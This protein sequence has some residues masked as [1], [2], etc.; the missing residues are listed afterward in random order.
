MFIKEFEVSIDF[1]I[2]LKI[3]I[4]AGFYVAVLQNLPFHMLP[5]M[6]KLTKL[7]RTSLQKWNKLLNALRQ[8]FIQIQIIGKGQEISNRYHSDQIEILKNMSSKVPILQES[9]I[10]II[11]GLIFLFLNRSNI[12][13]QI[14]VQSLIFFVKSVTSAANT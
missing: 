13:R 14:D 11:I 7:L 5:L 1:K 12:F 9:S 3:W 8:I 6:L 4:I 10:R 2:F